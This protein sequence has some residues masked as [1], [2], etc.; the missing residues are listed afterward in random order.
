MLHSGGRYGVARDFDTKHHPQVRVTECTAENHTQRRS[1]TS[2]YSHWNRQARAVSAILDNG[3]S[4]AA[5][6]NLSWRRAVD[7]SG[8][9]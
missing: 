3:A 6:V 4:A 5:S 1:A 8:T 9:P 7:F 2:T